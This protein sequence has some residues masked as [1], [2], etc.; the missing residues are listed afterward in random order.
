M[1]QNL[2]G[3]ELENAVHESN[4]LCAYVQVFQ[5]SNHK[6]YWTSVGRCVYFCRL[7]GHQQT[8]LVLLFFCH[9]QIYYHR[10]SLNLY[11]QWNLIQS[12]LD[13]NKELSHLECIEI[14]NYALEIWLVCPLVP[15]LR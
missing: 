12:D 8:K 6:H 13:G 5:M 9:T 1:S 11:R 10:H 4:P 3:Q 15:P 14:T 2:L 7:T